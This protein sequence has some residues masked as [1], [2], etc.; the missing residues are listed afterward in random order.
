MNSPLAVPV[1]VLPMLPQVLFSHIALLAAPLAHQEVL[2][3]G[4]LH[5][6]SLAINAPS[7]ICTQLPLP[8]LL[9][10]EQGPLLSELALESQSLPCPPLGSLTPHGA[11]SL[12]PIITKRFAHR[13]ESCGKVIAGYLN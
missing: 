4:S 6:T 10:P 1:S 13:N 11:C 12:H 2:T 8:T 7:Q 5:R 9:T 3:P